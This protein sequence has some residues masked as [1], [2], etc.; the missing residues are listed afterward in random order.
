MFKRIVWA[1]AALLIV[2]LVVAFFNRKLISRVNFS[3][4]ATDEKK[5]AENLRVL[6]TYYETNYIN[7]SASP[8]SFP[9]S[10]NIDS[11]EGKV[12]PSQFINQ[13]ETVNTQRFLEEVKAT[14]LLVLKDG[15]VVY[16]NY[17]NGLEPSQRQLAFSVGKSMTSVLVGFALQDGLIDSVTDPIVKY[18]PRYANTGW[19]KATI[20]NA[21]ENSSGVLFDEDYTR[22]DT[23]MRKFQMKFAFN[24]PVEPLLLGL[25]SENEPGTKHGYNSMDTQILGFL[26]TKVLAG[27]TIAQYW[28]EKVWGPLGAQD[29][30]TWTKDVTGQEITVGGLSMSLRDLA[31]VGQFYLQRGQWQ[32]QQLLSESWVLKSTTPEK[33]YQMPGRDNALSTKPFGYGYLWWIPIDPNGREFYASGLHGQFVFVNEDQGVVIAMYCANPKFNERPDW[34][35]ERHEDLF[36]TIAAGASAF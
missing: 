27:K 10:P 26:L 6:D 14:G 22:T 7:K 15:N 21:L 17:W 36:Q 25:G 16:E 3:L 30:A 2:L 29:D 12:V 9:R 5:I 28:Q 35:K 23:D 11:L 34:W 8:Y 33:P 31:K 32:G 20:E 1:V 24:R 18:L 4:N 19:A 13:G